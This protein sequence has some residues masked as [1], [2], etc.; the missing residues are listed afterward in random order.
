[1][2]TLKVE[3]TCM[4][5]QIPFLFLFSTLCTSLLDC[6]LVLVAGTQIALQS[7]D[8]AKVGLDYE[9]DP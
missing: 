8:G 1:M 3:A 9:L 2:L 7:P 4:H 6:S 5:S